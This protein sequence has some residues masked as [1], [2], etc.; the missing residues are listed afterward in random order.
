MSNWNLAEYAWPQPPFLSDHLA[1]MKI[2]MANI[3][4]ILCRH[5]TVVGIEYH[6]TAFSPFDRMHG[7]F[8]A[9]YLKPSK[10]PMA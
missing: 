2:K 3:A 9:K 10:M 1:E 6:K 7:Q 4:Q 8:W 5:R